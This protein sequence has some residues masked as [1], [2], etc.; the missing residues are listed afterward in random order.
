MSRP[1]TVTLFLFLL[2]LLLTLFSLRASSAVQSNQ[3]LQLG[4]VTSFGLSSPK[5]E[6]GVI[7][8]G[9]ST[10][11]S[12]NQTFELGFFST[13]E[14]AGWYLGIWYASNS[15]PTPTYVWVA[16]RE[17]PIMNITQSTLQI[18]EA[19][20]LAIKDSQNSIIWQST[21]TEKA[22]HFSFL[23]TGNLVLLSTEGLPVWQSFEHPTDTWLPGMNLSSDRSLTSWKSLSDPSPGFYSLRLKPRWFNEIELVYNGSL[24][25]WSTG[26]WTGNSFVNIP[27]MTIPYIYK[28]YF[29][30]PYRP[31]ATFG[32][33]EKSIDSGLKPP[34]TKFHLDPDRKSVV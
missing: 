17:K 14:E 20:K 33:T 4:A 31:T 11:L 21:N 22:T 8:A 18:C 1:T 5:N 27:E 12:E 26:N 30:N 13:N 19:G 7:V 24:V 16:N 29:V 3:D 23:D 2:L 28:F 34:L 6:T 25:Y 32:F 9:N 10:I 15:I